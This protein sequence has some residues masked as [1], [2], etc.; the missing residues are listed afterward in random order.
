VLD[1]LDRLVDELD[2]RSLDQLLVGREA[3]L[4]ALLP[5]V[6]AL[7]ERWPA[8]R[9]SLL[10]LRRVVEA[11]PPALT[12]MED[13]AAQALAAVLSSGPEL[14]RLVARRPHRLEHLLAPDLGRPWSR[15]ELEQDLDRALPRATQD[16]LTDE[17]FAESL[18]RFRNNHYVRLAACEF[19]GRPLEQVGLELA[20]LADLCLDR[21]IAFACA[22]LARAVGEPLVRDASGERPARL[23]A[24]AMGK[25][26][27]QE[28]NFCSDIDVV[29]V[30]TSDEGQAG[31]LTLH[32][33]FARVCQQVTRI[34]SEPNA[35][36]IVFRVDL[37]LRPEGSRG[38][39][40]NALAG[41]ER[42]YETWGGPYDRLAWL[43]ARAAAGDRELGEQMI[44]I[45]RPFVFPRSTRPEVVDQIQQ[46]YRRLGSGTQAGAEGWNV[47]LGGGGIRQVEFFVQALQLL[48]AGKQEALQERATLRALD[49]LLFL[50]LITEHEQ[51]QLAEAYA[52]WRQIEHRVQLYDGRQTHLLPRGP[53]RERVA[54]HLGREPDVFAAELDARRGQ[55][56]AIYATLDSAQQGPAEGGGPSP[57]E[58]PSG[59]DLAPLLDRDLPR[60]QAVQLLGRAGF[61]QAERAAEQLE[62]LASKPW[63]PLGHAPRGAGR[64]ALPL[65]AELAR[66][67]DPDASLHHTVELT[68]RF[69]PYAGL[70]E[71]LDRNRSTLRLLMSLFGSSDHL[72]RLFINHPELVDQLLA[73]GRVHTRKSAAVMQ[74][75]LEQ[76][77]EGSADTEDRLNRVRRFRNEEVLRIGLHDIA[78]DLEP[79]DLFAQLSD[80]AQVIV[81]QVYPVVLGDA[82]GRY[83]TPRHADGAPAA[84]TI[85]GLGKLGAR[86]LT[87][88]SDL[89]LIFVYSDGGMTDGVAQRS[90]DNGE[91][92]ARVAQRLIGALSAALEEGRLY[93]V[94]SRLRPSGNQGTLVSSRPA[95]EAYHHSAGQLWERQVLVKARTVAGDLE[96][97]RALERWIE[98]F[99]YESPIDPEQLRQELDR[100]RTRQEKELAEE[101]GDFYNLKLGRGGL[102]DVDFVVQYH[103]LCHGGRFPSVR[104]RGTPEAL[105]SLGEEGLIDP[106]TTAALL[107][108][109]RFL[110]RIENR[111]RIVRD[112]SAERLP[113]SARGLEVMA[114]RLGYRQ[115]AT[116]TPG[117]Q[118]LA[119]YQ[120]I[121]ESTRGIYERIFRA[122]GRP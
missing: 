26:G 45:L 110:R 1:A 120:E 12:S 14:G 96:L 21:A 27:A 59:V 71:M 90:V 48:H 97:G 18:A 16:R 52:L 19:L 62:L 46:L 117:A 69:G 108:S 78:G 116:L 22:G 23:A 58:V 63:G 49:K 2:G 92:F 41:A 81:G 37:R 93:E 114:R 87:Y 36:G 101:N 95:F 70:W 73:A 53:Q 67:P 31:A 32:E 121:T 50:G 86:E 13:R 57:L 111:L 7:A 33:F 11:G 55:V 34:L 43:K 82:Q 10:N 47:K 106:Q 104:R 54:R 75:E 102:L 94:D 119:E 84:M 85:I 112:R 61:G 44:R 29:F 25:H 40:C 99:V 66:S 30:Y 3:E 80:L 17:A 79:E 72:A 65:L 109:Y 24:V 56:Q 4:G 5:V 51:R 76:K 83:G 91:F 115:Q 88:A 28:L 77:L 105:A 118:L 89:D 74:R 113:K 8:P 68:L 42:Y 39:I 98:P 60:E 35:E 100:H 103:Q 122:A 20:N 38:P 107:R 64:L 9:E 6:R 15:A